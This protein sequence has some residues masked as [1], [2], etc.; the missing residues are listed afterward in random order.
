MLCFKRGEQQGDHLSP[1]LF[2]L[3]KDV[4]SRGITSVVDLGTLKPMVGPW[5]FSTPFNVL[6]ENDIMVFCKGTKCN[7]ESLV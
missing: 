1:L 3:A 5:K 4:L 7:F 2:S 6:Y